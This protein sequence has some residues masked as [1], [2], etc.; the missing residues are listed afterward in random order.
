MGEH[1]RDLEAVL[2]EIKRAGLTV[3]PEKCRLGMNKTQYL[4][5]VIGKER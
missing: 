3:N 4:G 5:F 1:V 2:T